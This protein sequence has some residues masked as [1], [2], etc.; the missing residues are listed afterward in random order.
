[1]STHRHRVSKPV[2]VGL[3][4]EGNYRR[5]AVED[6]DTTGGPQEE[7]RKEGALADSIRVWVAWESRVRLR[8]KDKERSREAC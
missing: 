1:M 2:L 5:H 7:A 4:V 6:D 3:V 8:V